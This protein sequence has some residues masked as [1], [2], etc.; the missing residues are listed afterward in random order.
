MPAAHKRFVLLTGRLPIGR[1]G[2]CLVIIGMMIL[3]ISG[4]WGASTDSTS[5]SLRA[6]TVI[7][8]CVTSRLTASSLKD[9][10]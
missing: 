6:C 2:Q 3:H 10:K 8:T 4:A 1:L 7:N 9:K 5:A